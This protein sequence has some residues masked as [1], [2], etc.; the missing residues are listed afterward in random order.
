MYILDSSAIIELIRG[1]VCGEKIRILL[2]DSPFAVTAISI[3]EILPGTRGKTREAFDF[4]FETVPVFGLDKDTAFLC[5]EIEEDLREK[6]KKMQWS[7]VF[8][9]GVCQNNNAILVTADK[10]F[11]NISQISSRIIEQ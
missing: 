5:V 1:S 8:I 11:R 4:L 3:P 7:D 6:G 2:K 9:A 10:G